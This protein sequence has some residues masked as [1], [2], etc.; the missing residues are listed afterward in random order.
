MP[1]QEFV[2]EL[3]AYRIHERR[4][5]SPGRREEVASSRCTVSSL[6]SIKTV[7]EVLLAFSLENAHG[8][9]R[10]ASMK[11]RTTA[12]AMEFGAEAVKEA[13]AD[14]YDDPH[15]YCDLGYLTNQGADKEAIKKAVGDAF[16]ELLGLCNDFDVNFEVERVKRTD[17]ELNRVLKL[18]GLLEGPQWPSPSP[19][20]PAVTTEPLL[21]EIGGQAHDGPPQ[22]ASRFTPGEPP[23]A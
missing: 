20:P 21:S 18:M 12:K 17:F 2:I 9:S 10:G 15:G 14:F 23:S 22:Q 1:E 6:H 19:E 8:Q 16:M 3:T 11:E 5:D 13:I 4:T 7:Q